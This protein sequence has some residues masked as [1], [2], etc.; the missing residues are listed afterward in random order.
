MILIGLLFVI[1]LY[2]WKI[3]AEQVINI[4]KKYKFRK[5]LRCFF[6]HNATS[7]NTY[8]K[9]ISTTI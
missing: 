8:V 4:I 1:D 9:I 2:T 7:N 6:L 5:Q 3:V